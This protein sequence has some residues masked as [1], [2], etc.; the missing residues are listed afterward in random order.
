MSWIWSEICAQPCDL[1]KVPKGEHR[2]VEN[3]CLQ[4]VESK[5]LSQCGKLLMSSL[6]GICNLVTMWKKLI[7]FR[8]WNPYLFRTWNFPPWIHSLSLRAVWTVA[9][10]KRKKS[11]RWGKNITLKWRVFNEKK[12][13]LFKT[14]MKITPLPEPQNSIAHN[15]TAIKDTHHLLK[16]VST[17]ISHQL[18]ISDCLIH[19]NSVS[20]AR[21]F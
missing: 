3:R 7:T 18:M 1:L 9:T 13:W 15:S 5:N 8:T 20:K 11:R 17:T 12:Q 4:Y 6:H 19:V 21:S 16:F 14:N 2:Y 10:C